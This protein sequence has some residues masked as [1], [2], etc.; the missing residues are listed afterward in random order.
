AYL[1][2]NVYLLMPG[3]TN[4]LRSTH[5]QQKMHDLLPFFF[6]CFY[7]SSMSFGTGVPVDGTDIISIVICPHII[8][9]NA[10]AFKYRV[11]ITLHLVSNGFADEN[12]IFPQLFDEIPINTSFHKL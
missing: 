10:G 11:K 6:E 2:A 12:F 5:I 9:G 4:L 8:K 1:F 3:I 7:K